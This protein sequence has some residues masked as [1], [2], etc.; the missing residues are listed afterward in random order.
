MPDVA[1]VPDVPLVPV[2]PE[3]AE[4][5]DVPLV[6]VSNPR[7]PGIPCGPACDMITLFKFSVIFN[8]ST[9][10]VYCYSFVRNYKY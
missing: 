9:G 7:G 2:V 6:P 10:I 5:P 3:V 4:V 1:L 8:T